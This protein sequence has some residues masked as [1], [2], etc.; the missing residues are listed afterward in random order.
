MAISLVV[1]P[2]FRHTHFNVR[3]D[4]LDP[5][6]RLFEWLPAGWLWEMV[7][8]W[9]SLSAHAVG[10]QTVQQ[11]ASIRSAVERMRS[12]RE[13]FKEKANSTGWCE[14]SQFIFPS[15]SIVRISNVLVWLYSQI[16]NRPKALPSAV[17]R[18]ESFSLP[19]ASSAGQVLNQNFT[20]LN[21]V[22]SFLT[23][24]LPD[25]PHPLDLQGSALKLRVAVG[26]AA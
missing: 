9:N 2:I 6:D 10:R 16:W 8:T 1:Y 4:P 11:Q 3:V 25:P 23:Q 18:L 24:T 13:T 19:C 17:V 22:F 21:P 15:R 20:F 12:N 14:L 7:S 5:V 26:F